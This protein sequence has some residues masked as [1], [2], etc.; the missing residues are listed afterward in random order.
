MNNLTNDLT[1]IPA[2]ACPRCGGW[3][4]CGGMSQHRFSDVRVIDRTGCNCR[5]NRCFAPV[6]EDDVRAV[7][8]TRSSLDQLI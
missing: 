7:M 6:T 1:K 3:T 2:A 8:A 4:S 5:E